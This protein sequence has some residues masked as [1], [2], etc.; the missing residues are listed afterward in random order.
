MGV[1]NIKFR[2]FSAT[3][4]VITPIF[5]ERFDITFSSALDRASSK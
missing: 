2:E 4:Y 3:L 5:A 1:L